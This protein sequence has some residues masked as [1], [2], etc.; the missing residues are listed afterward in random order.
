MSGVYYVEVPGLSPAEAG[1]E[2]PGGSL[3]FLDP[4][5]SA[6]VQHLKGRRCTHSYVPSAGALIIF[7]SYQMH[8]VFP[9]RSPGERISVAFNA[10]LTLI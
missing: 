8:A 4:R 9:Y 3:V 5:Q 6:N 10:R 2:E 7:P 1:E